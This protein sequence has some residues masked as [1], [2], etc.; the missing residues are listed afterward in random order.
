M[1]GRGQYASKGKDFVTRGESKIELCVMENR[2][3]A[4][5]TEK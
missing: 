5:N 4:G 2:Q 3:I 1:S